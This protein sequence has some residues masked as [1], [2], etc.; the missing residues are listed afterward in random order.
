MNKEFIFGCLFILSF[1]IIGDFNHSSSNINAP[2]INANTGTSC[3]LKEIS[4]LRL[5]ANATIQS[6]Q[7]LSFGASQAYDRLAELNQNC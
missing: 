5:A 7:D 3:Y 2:M 6:Q 4:S 1:L